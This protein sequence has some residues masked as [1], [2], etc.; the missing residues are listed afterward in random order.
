[1]RG[2]NRGLEEGNMMEIIILHKCQNEIHARY[3]HGDSQEGQDYVKSLLHKA[4]THTHTYT[5][6][7][8]IKTKP[9]NH[10]ILFRRTLE[11]VP[12]K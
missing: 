5:H 6:T 1:V 10:K 2:M 9:T 8:V 7:H 12:D 11:C 3:Q 4:N